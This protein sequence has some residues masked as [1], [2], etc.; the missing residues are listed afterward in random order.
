MNLYYVADGPRDK[1]VVPEL[2]KRVLPTARMA[3]FRSWK[4]HLRGGGYRKKLRFAIR[5]AR[6]AGLDG[7]VATLD[8]DS[9]KKGRRCQELRAGRDEE[10]LDPK[11]APMPVAT[12]EACPHTEAWLLDDDVA[13]RSSLSTPPDQPVQSLKNCKDPKQALQVLIEQFAPN[14]ETLEVLTL[15]AKSVDP[16]R[17]NHA[18]ETGLTDF[19]QDVRAE[20]GGD[21]GSR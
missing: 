13:V 12:G 18:N 8:Q 5:A 16:A 17:C 21:S 1:A 10:R 20:L 3:H 9:E 6:D 2:V 4:L 11:H 14:S 15:I 19:L 7:V